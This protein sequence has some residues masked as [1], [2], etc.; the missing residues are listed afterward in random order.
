MPRGSILRARVD[1]SVHWPATAAG[2]KCQTI[3]ILNNTR[4]GLVMLTSVIKM[5]RVDW[6]AK[7][8]SYA[9]IRPSFIHNL[10]VNV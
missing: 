6:G 2:R 8:L 9:K 4:G 5:R 3:E 10:K 1:R 7:N